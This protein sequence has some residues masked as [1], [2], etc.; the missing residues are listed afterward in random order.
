MRPKLFAV[1]CLTADRCRGST[2]GR[3]CVFHA[4]QRNAARRFVVVP[5]AIDFAKHVALLVAATL[6]AAF[7]WTEN[8]LLRQVLK[9]GTAE[10]APLAL[11]TWVTTAKWTCLVVTV[12]LALVVVVGPVWGL[13]VGLSLLLVLV[14]FGH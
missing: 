7:D 10:T 5:I 12:G 13:A 1:R 8:R 2:A 11:A 3:E 4:L 6:T 9:S 14:G